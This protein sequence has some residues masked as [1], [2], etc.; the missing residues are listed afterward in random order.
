MN[1][2]VIACG[3]LMLAGF[4][5]PASFDASATDGG[6]NRVYFDGSPRQ[7]SYDCTACHTEPTRQ[8]DAKLVVTPAV[9]GAY[10]A[11]TLYTIEVSLVGEHLGFGTA[12]NQNGFVA[13]LVDDGGMPAGTL[14]TPDLDKVKTI[15]D[16][17][18]VSGEGKDLTAW[19]F[20]WTAPSAGRG[21]V[22][23]HLGIVDGNGA[24]SA[25]VPQNDPGGDDVAVA[26]LRLC[27]GSPGCA[28]R[29]APAITDSKAAGCSAAGTSS[30]LLVLLV[31]LGLRGRRRAA[32][33]ACALAGCFA[34]TT[35]ADCPDHVCGGVSGGDAGSMCAENWVC[36]SWEAPLGSDQATRTCTDKNSVGTTDCKPATAA[37]LPALDLEYFKCNVAPIFQRGCG[38]MACHGTDT[39]HAFRIYTRGRLRNKQMVFPVN[40]C[41]ENPNVKVDLQ[42]RGTGTVM[43]EGWSAHTPEE[44][45]KNFDSSRSF[46]LGVANPD[47]SL[48]LR[49]AAKGG[50][51]HAQVKLFASGDP[52]YQTIRSWL[53]GATL[54]R[55]CNVGAN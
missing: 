21:A 49:E 38:Q 2:F 22:T 26:K 5:Q 25:A 44:W 31:L 17:Q 39:E 53:G 12:N 42:I 52:E 1:R 32:L 24:A 14:A 35:P 27:E 20:T 41:L 55:T 4:H 6:G 50:L 18:V 48:L 11:G 9:T 37:T 8:I 45:K 34:P 23:L 46:M 30:P 15:D 13:E 3:F 29:V 40:S 7:K 10:Q 47:D 16:G 36:S 54:G 51:P 33:L 19:S 43:C 28:D